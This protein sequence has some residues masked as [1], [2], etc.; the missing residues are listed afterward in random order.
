MSEREFHDWLSRRLATSDK[1][2]LAGTGADDCALLN[3]EGLSRLA[4]STDTIV[5]GTHFNAEE[6][7]LVVGQKAAAAA[8]SDL[9]ASGCRARWG[10]IALNMR[11]GLGDRWAMRLTEGI[12]ATARK[13]GLSI[14]GGDTTSAYGPTSVNLTVIGTPYGAEPVPRAGAKPGDLLLLTGS[15]GGSILGRHLR[16]QP[17]FAEIELLLTLSPVHA[18]MDISDGLALDLSRLLG[19]SNLGATIEES[20]IPVSDDARKLAQS[21]GQSPM[22]HALSDGED[23]EL[24]VCVPA[25]NVGAIMDGWKAANM[26]TPLSC[27]GRVEAASSIRIA[28]R[29]G[30]VKLLTPTGYDHS[31]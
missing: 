9:A 25:A 22:S 15:L 19:A 17:R 2:V 21:S 10:L 28:S 18:A 11:R 8:L 1:T 23:F 5:E 20:E 14:V 7:P 3:I 30:T 24:L 16:P 6:D 26:K 12:A 4:V 13:Y 29:D 31:F 27:I